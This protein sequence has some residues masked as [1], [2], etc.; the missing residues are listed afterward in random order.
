VGAVEVTRALLGLALVVLAGCFGPDPQVESVRADPV[1]DGR[2]VVTVVLRNRGRGEGDASVEVTLRDARTR[3]IVGRRELTV[4]LHP[5]EHVTTS[6]SVPVADATAVVAEA[7][8]S[9][10]P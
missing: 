2:S 7:D 9:Y 6:L 3:E 8:A 10:P 5:H 1:R 4:P